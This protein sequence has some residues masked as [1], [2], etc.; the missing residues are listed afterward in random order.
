MHIAGQNSVRDWSQHGL[1]ADCNECQGQWLPAGQS[2]FCDRPEHGL[3]ADCNDRQ[4]Q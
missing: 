1:G 2:S 4:G 3:G